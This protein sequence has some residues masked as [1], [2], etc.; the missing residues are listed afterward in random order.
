MQDLDRAL[1]DLSTIRLQIARQ[2]P[3]LGLGSGALAATG[4]IAL[5]AGFAQALWLDNPTERPVAFFALWIAVAIVCAALIGAETW[6]RASRFHRGMSDEMVIQ[7]VEGFLPVGGAGACLTLAFAKFA[8]DQVWMLPGLWQILI[9]IGIF[10]SLRI[11]PR[12]CMFVG[13]WYVLA[14]LGVFA[15]A[16]GEHLLSSCLMA[17]PFA[18]GQAALARIMHVQAGG[19][20]D[21]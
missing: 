13:A 8:P 19:F 17:V 10:G 14:G 6:R 16:S 21:V 15:L 18:V 9:G 7:T 4:A 11:L 3:F 2:T 1:D 5:F 12:Q 20:D